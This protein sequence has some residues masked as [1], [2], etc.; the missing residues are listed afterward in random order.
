MSHSGC[1]LTTSHGP[2]ISSSNF[3]IDLWAMAESLPFSSGGNSFVGSVAHVQQAGL[4]SSVSVCL[5]NLL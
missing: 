1:V 5:E 3:C 2:S 4:T